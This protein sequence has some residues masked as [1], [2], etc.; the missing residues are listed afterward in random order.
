M[1]ILQSIAGNKTILKVALGQITSS[2]DKDG[3]SAIV[4]LR[5]PN[6][7]EEDA[8]G[9]SVKTY[10]ENIG[11]LSGEDLE[12]YKRF[13]AEKFAGS[14]MITASEFAEYENLKNKQSLHHV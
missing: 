10:K 8:N 4:I 12:E 9:L 3:M 6:S 1:N 11:I 14:K 7:T 5:D 2:M 13:L